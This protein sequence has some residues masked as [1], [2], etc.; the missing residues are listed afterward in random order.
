I[1]KNNK[2]I[3]EYCTTNVLLRNL[4]KGEKSGWIYEMGIPVQQID[5]KFNIDVQQRIPMNDNRDVVNYGYLPT[6][7]AAI[8]DNII[9]T[10]SKPILKERWVLAGL[11]RSQ[12]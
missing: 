9:H 3:E 4:R 5:T 6:V 10:I 8:L 1:I 11:G 12:A 7:F 2:Q